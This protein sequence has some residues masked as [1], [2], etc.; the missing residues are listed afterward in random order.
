MG[1]VASYTRDAGLQRLAFNA[2]PCGYADN[3]CEQT[4]TADGTPVA[5]RFFHPAPRQTIP[6]TVNDAKQRWLARLQYTDNRMLC[7]FSHGNS[8][9]LGTSAPYSQWL[10]D[11]FEMNVVAYDYPVRLLDA[12]AVHRCRAALYCVMR[13]PCCI[14]S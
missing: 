6:A 11:A 3:E 1:A 8:D 5:L 9:D 10:A 14:V 2:P 4:A 13:A 7:I 12:A